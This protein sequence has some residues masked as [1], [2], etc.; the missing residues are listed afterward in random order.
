MQSRM[1]AEQRTTDV[2][3]R[4]AEHVLGDFEVPMI[5]WAGDARPTP[6]PVLRYEVRVVAHNRGERT[7]SL[8]QL[9]LWDPER[10]HG[11][12]EQISE[13]L[14]PGSAIERTLV[15]KRELLE[16][17]AKAGFVAVAELGSG[18]EATSGVVQLDQS[19]L[20]Q[21]RAN[22]SEREGFRRSASR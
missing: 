14:S 21:L 22:V 12:A 7:E 15:I 17:A 10:E 5:T 19:L 18:H 16:V 3:V 6:P 8:R 1:R 2:E 9:A 11:Q 4:I 13:P 20:E